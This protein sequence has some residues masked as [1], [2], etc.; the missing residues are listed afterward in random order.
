MAALFNARTALL[1]ALDLPGFGLQLIDR[2][3]QATGGR[4]RLGMG[5][6]Y[7]LLNRLE[8]DGLV[9]SRAVRVRPAGRPTK[10]YELTPKGLRARQAEREAVI[11]LLRTGEPAVPAPDPMTVRRR[12]ER[13]A[14]VSGAALELRRRVLAQAAR[15]PA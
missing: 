1:L 10:Y 15:G 7:P 2:V 4:A 3:R 8:R 11:G 12:F 5:S 6:V 13:C 9:R 14:E